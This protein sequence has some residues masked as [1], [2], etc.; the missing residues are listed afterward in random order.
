VCVCVCYTCIY[1]HALILFNVR[2]TAVGKL[3]GHGVEGCRVKPRHTIKLKIMKGS[4]SETEY[5]LLILP[6]LVDT[7]A[8]SVSRAVSQ[9]SQEQEQFCFGGL[10]KI[11]GA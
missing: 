2:P 8:G 10:S 6:W 3:G 5:A 9:E 11:L 7:S 4:A 1:T